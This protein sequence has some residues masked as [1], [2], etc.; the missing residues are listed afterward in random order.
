MALIPA[1]IGRSVDAIWNRDTRSLLTWTAVVFGL[2]VAQA[3]TSTLRH[4]MAVFNWLSAAY[5][6][7]QVTVRQATRLGAT[8]PRRVSTGEV[9]S[10]GNSDIAHIGNAMDILL[11][12]T[13]AV[14]AIVT[15]TVILI[16][17]SPALGL[18]VLVGVPIMAVAV[19]PLLRP[20]H[21]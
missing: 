1:A 15:V 16:S 17:T 8:L 13:G 2:G 10:V 3:V 5:R 6:T 14:V 19:G 20:L 21:R 4:R 18:T 7:V 11:R 12:G 9:V